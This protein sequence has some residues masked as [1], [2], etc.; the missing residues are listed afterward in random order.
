MASERNR[1]GYSS[2][3]DVPIVEVDTQ[4]RSRRAAVPRRMTTLGICRVC[5]V[6]GR[7]A[8]GTRVPSATTADKRVS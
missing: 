5:G 4:C 7:L 2:T 6:A 8:P 3:M 1:V